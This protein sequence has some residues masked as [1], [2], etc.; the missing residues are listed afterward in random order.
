MI[1]TKRVSSLPITHDER[2]TIDLAL[3]QSAVEQVPA[4][5]I[6]EQSWIE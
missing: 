6:E 5:D 1:T 3:R 4:N 2:Q